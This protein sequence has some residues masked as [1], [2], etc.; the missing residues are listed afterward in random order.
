MAFNMF[1]QTVQVAYGS[2]ALAL[3]L[4]KHIPECCNQN[5]AMRERV[6]GRPLELA[7]GWQFQQLL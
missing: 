6:A 5:A 4:V 2:K 7:V 1:K 3:S